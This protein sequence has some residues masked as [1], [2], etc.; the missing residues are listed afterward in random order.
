MASF[1]Y[2]GRDNTGKQVKGAIEAGNASTA[3]EQ[4][5]RKNIIPISISARTKHK[6]GSIAQKDVSEIFGFNKVSLDELIIFSR[7]MYALM[8][9]GVPILRAI[10]RYG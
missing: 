9:S 3:A 5:Q 6:T 2:I 8:R 7:Q 10:T 4:L 1:S